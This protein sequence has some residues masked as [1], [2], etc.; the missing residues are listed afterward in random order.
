MNLFSF[1]GANWK[2]SAS[3]YAETLCLIVISICLLPADVWTIPRVF[4]PAIGLI[5]AKTVKDSLTKDK[6]VTGGNV[7]QTLEGGFVEKGKQDLVDMTL[8]ASP[9]SEQEA[10][11]EADEAASKTAKKG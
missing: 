2:T 5:I 3:G 1:F 7:Q 8:V 6:N 10:I 11:K 4:L 9:K